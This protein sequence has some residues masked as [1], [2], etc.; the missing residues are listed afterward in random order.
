MTTGDAQFADLYNRYYRQV[1]AYCRRRTTGEHAEDAVAE[2]F[3]VA[4]RRVDDIPQGEGTLPW[5]YRVAYRTLGHQW[6]GAGRRNRLNKRL[7]SVGVEVVNPPDD[8]FLIQE[9]RSQVREATAKLKTADIEVLRL[10]VWEELPQSD[11]AIA[12]DL[13]VDA[14]R[15]R[16]SRAKKNLTA[17]YN[18]LEDRRIKPP[19]VQKGGGR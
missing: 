13:S 8:H 14:V 3:L 12:L 2:T 17:E 16:L 15:Q 10:A 19:A 9:Q 5:L 4:W 7:S 18:R 6:R 11:I 1:Y